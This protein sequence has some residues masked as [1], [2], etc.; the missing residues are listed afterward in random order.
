MSSAR[1]RIAAQP[2]DELGHPTHLVPLVE[3]LVARGNALA[4]PSRPY[5]GFIPSPSGW[6]CQLV[7]PIT[8]G[9]WAALNE[10]F[11]I[12]SNIVY[13]VGA[14]RDNRTWAQILGGY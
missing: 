2:D 4:T 11:E 10:K 13:M 8:P 14:I 9:D 5:D 6:E 3:E 7:R 12:P 1:P